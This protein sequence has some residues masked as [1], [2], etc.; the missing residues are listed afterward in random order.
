MKGN[1]VVNPQ[2]ISHDT[3]LNNFTRKKKQV[4]IFIFDFEKRFQYTVS[5]DVNF[6]Y[7]NHIE[8]EYLTTS[9]TGLTHS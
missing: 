8:M 7:L 4:D 5:C 9:Y 6:W 1:T 3:R 2:I